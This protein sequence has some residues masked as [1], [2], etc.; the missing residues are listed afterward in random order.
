MTENLEENVGSASVVRIATR[1]TENS[2]T[3]CGTRVVTTG[4]IIRTKGSSK[5]IGP[6]AAPARP[7][8]MAAS[9]PPRRA[10]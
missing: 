9:I 7:L 6:A 3:G 5:T 2:N 4:A 1:K 8:P 10:K